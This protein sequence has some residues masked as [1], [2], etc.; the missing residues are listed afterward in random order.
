MKRICCL[1][2]VICVYL[3]GCSQA[4]QVENHAYVLV[5]GLEH[6]LDGQLQMSVLVPRISGNQG[7][8]E[9]QSGSGSYTHLVITADNYAEA[10]ARLNWGF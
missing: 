3:C 8:A 4:S 5:M 10:L 1:L 2:M 6:T 7:N 9:G